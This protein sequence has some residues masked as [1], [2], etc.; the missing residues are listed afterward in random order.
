MATRIG[1]TMFRPMPWADP[2]AKPIRNLRELFHVF[3]ELM[4]LSKL[5]SDHYFDEASIDSDPN[6]DSVYLPE[7]FV[8]CVE[9]AA[10]DAISLELNT[11]EW[12]VQTDKYTLRDEISK[13]DGIENI[14]P[15][16]AAHLWVTDK[17][18]FHSVINRLIPHDGVA[19]RGMDRAYGNI[20]RFL[21]AMKAGLQDPVANLIDWKII[22]DGK[23][24]KKV[25]LYS[26]RRSAMDAMVS[27]A[28]DR[29]I[30]RL[31]S[32]LATTP[33][34]TTAHIFREHDEGKG[35]LVEIHV[36]L[37]QPS[38]MAWGSP[39]N[40]VEQEILFLP[41]TVLVGMGADEEDPS[42]LRYRV[43]LDSDFD[44]GWKSR[45]KGPVHMRGVCL[46]CGGTVAE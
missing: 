16:T 36:H 1:S 14:V 42:R 30:S 37:S 26:G 38:H 11:N 25:V 29:N 31:V 20:A 24:V 19:V 35:P 9:R 8:N 43:A 40:D 32:V 4:K 41:G 2:E 23:A 12:D 22:P 5:H 39:I 17:P 15:L 6:V 27:A 46:R 18:E 34:E 21:V 44:P 3:N 7:C 10:G 13:Y 45:S 33:D 28:G